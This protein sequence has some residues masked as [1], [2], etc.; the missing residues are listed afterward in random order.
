LVA[1][2]AVALLADASTG[3]WDTVNWR[4][5]ALLLVTGAAVV[6][7]AARHPA[8]TCASAMPSRPLSADTSAVVKLHSRLDVDATAS[9]WCH[10]SGRGPQ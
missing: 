3:G 7:L 9:R 1:I 5:L 10:R 8:M 6:A 4:V 2:L